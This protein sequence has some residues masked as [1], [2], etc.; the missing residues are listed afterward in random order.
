MTVEASD[1]A[2]GVIARDG[3]IG[4]S[5]ADTVVFTTDAT[6]RD[7]TRRSASRWLPLPHD[8]LRYAVFSE[9]GIVLGH[10]RVEGRVRGGGEIQDAGKADV[11]GN[12]TTLS[13]MSVAAS[14]DDGDTDVFYDSQPLSLPA[15]D[16]SW[17]QAAGEEIALPTPGTTYSGVV[18]SPAANPY[19]AP[20]PSGI[21]WIDAGAA[22]STSWTVRST[23]ASP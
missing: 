5:D 21:Y 18:V 8:A 23:P 15:I 1:P 9:T 6:V 4:S 16:F 19:G 10:V 14:L 17:F 11:Y 7:V 13:G 22:R 12:I 20:S 3:S 2:D